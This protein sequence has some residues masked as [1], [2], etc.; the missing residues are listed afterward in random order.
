MESAAVSTIAAAMMIAVA[1]AFWRV[2][3]GWPAPVARLDSRM[4]VPFAMG[5][6]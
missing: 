6:G 3:I 5:R 4:A 1:T 2:S